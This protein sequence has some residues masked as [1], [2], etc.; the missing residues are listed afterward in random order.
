MFTTFLHQLVPDSNFTILN[1]GGFR[2][3]WYP[4]VV[5]FEQYYNMFPF[6]NTIATFTI[7]GSELTNSLNVI[8]S[9]KDLFATW[10]LQVSININGTGAK[11]VTSSSF[12]NGSPIDP[13]AIYKGV[14]I[15]Y[16][17][18]GGDRMSKVIGYT[19]NATNV[20]VMGDF[21]STMK[22]Y[23]MGIGTARAGMFTDPLNPT[24]ILNYI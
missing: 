2:T 8:Q 12:S 7:K 13:N 22:S 1:T 15:K 16:L 9:G 20:T 5:T 3:Q 21:R 23:L 24:I 4:G 17:L 10:G 19:Y 6:D 18:D 14:T 11:L